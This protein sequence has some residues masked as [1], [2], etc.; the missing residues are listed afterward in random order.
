MRWLE[1]SVRVP[2]ELADNI[3]EVLSRYAPHGIA[4][5]YGPIE[6]DDTDWERPRL[7]P[8]ILTLRVYLPMTGDWETARQ[9]I[10]EGLWH[11]RQVL[12]FPPPQFRELDETMW[13]EAWKAHYDVLRVGPFVI[14]PS[15]RT[16]R[17]EPGDL[18]IELDPGMAFGTGT[19]PTTR[20]CL[21]AIAEWVRAGDRVLDLGTGSG[22]L[23]I[24]AARRGAA[25]VWALDVDPVAVQ[26]AQEN[27]IRNRVADR[28]VVMRGSLEEARALGE[29]FDGVVA[30]IV[31]PVICSFCERGIVEL[32]Q[33]RGWLVVSG[34][35]HGE[36]EEAVRRALEA[37]GLT[38]TRRWIEESWVALGAR[39]RRFG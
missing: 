11:L 6:T 10:E 23:A 25:R 3:A 9:R 26:V 22:I 14:R 38:V 31:A 20:M 34:F 4:Y 28:V 1:I 19:H 27:M 36:Q 12:P 29:R 24:A 35:F 5:D 33:P 16:A 7:P 37:T 18:L 30:N 32:L 17:L 21:Q 39:R 8:P 13:E 2:T 15:W